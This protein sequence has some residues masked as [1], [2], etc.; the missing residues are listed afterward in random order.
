M[1]TPKKSKVE[2]V[3]KAMKEA[4]EYEEEDAHLPG[5]QITI[6]MGAP[7][8]RPTKD[9]HNTHKPE[10]K[11]TKGKRRKG[12]VGPMEEALKGAY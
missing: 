9:K 7:V 10:H 12:V 8:R 4:A 3:E 5:F 1:N 2:K 6:S 11:K